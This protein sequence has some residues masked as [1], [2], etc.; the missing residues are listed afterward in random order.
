MIGGDRLHPLGL[1]GRTVLGAVELE[2]KRRLALV[3]FSDQSG[4]GAAGTRGS[5]RS[6][7]TPMK[8]MLSSVAAPGRSFMLYVT[9]RMTMPKNRKLRF[10]AMPSGRWAVSSQAMA[11]VDSL[12]YSRRSTP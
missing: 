9:A 5:V 3:A 10:P 1:F 12:A 8:I 6:M 11:A 4:D 7:N 2:E